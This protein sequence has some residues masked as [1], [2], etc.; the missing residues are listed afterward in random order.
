[1]KRVPTIPSCLLAQQQQKVPQFTISNSSLSSTGGGG[2]GGGGIG[3]SA[4]LSPPTITTSGPYGRGSGTNLRDSGCNLIR[5]PWKIVLLGDAG[6]GKS[7]LVRQLLNGGFSMNYNPTVEDSYQ[8]N[9]NL[10]G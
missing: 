2:G 10:P 5:V 4:S 6:V 7:S 1:M 9:I 8:H 3:G